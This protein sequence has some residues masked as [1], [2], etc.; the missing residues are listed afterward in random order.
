MGNSR[1]QFNSS[2]DYFGDAFNNSIQRFANSARGQLILARYKPTTVTRTEPIGAG[3]MQMFTETVWTN[4][5]GDKITI[6]PTTK[7]QAIEYRAKHPIRDA[8]E[9]FGNQLLFDAITLGQGSLWKYGIMPILK[10]P[11]IQKVIGDVA[12]GTAIN[13]A[14]NNI[15][16]K[17]SGSKNGYMDD[18]FDTIGGN[19]ISNPYAKEGTKFIFNL[20]NPAYLVGASTSQPVTNFFA[21]ADDFLINTKRGYDFVNNRVRLQNNFN[22]SVKST[23]FDN[24][25]I[26][27][28]TVAKNGITRGSQMNA[29]SDNDVG[30]HVSPPG[31]NTYKIIADNS[32]EP[33]VIR[34]GILPISSNYKISSAIDEGIWDSSFNPD[35]YYSRPWNYNVNLENIHMQNAIQVGEVSPIIQYINRFENPGAKDLAIFDSSIIPPLSKNLFTHYNPIS[36]LEDYYNNVNNW[37]IQVLQPEELMYE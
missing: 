34:T 21:N 18:A 3:G 8:S 23:I 26:K 16:Q 10:S 30:F 12:L 28:A 14:G 17:V 2:P 31:S 6:D 9:N 4:D 24:I 1:N 20:L 32:E 37:K 7:Q 25:P 22:N 19:N 11:T 35:L 27:H 13:E 33:M 15:H 36:A 5:K 29:F